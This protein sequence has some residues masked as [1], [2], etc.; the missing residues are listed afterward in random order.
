[1]S[2]DLFTETMD[3]ITALYYFGFYNDSVL[4][5]KLYLQKTTHSTQANIM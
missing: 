4:I 5:T 1:M 2:F 3:I